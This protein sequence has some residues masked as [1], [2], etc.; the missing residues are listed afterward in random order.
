MDRVK[1]LKKKIPYDDAYFD[2]Q[3]FERFLKVVDTT[4]PPNTTT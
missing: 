1:L 3:V 4:I 2:A